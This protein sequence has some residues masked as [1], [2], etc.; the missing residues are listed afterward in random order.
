MTIHIDAQIPITITGTPDVVYDKV[1]ISN[2]NITT[3]LGVSIS[4]IVEFRYY[5]VLDDGGMQEAP[6]YLGSRMLSL[7]D[8]NQVLAAVEGGSDLK[9]GVEYAFVAL[10]KAYGVI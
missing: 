1:Y 3:I 10:G 4:A 6:L 7:P 2:L 9:N 5:R 8:L